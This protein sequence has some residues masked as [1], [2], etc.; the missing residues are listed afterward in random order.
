MS[1]PAAATLAVAVFGLAGIVPVLAL[2]GA[3]LVSLALAPLFGALLGALAGACCIAI[4]GSLLMWFI[5]WSGL[6]AALGAVAIL[7]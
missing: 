5:I 4:A 2:V 6:A 3:R 7:G 1:D